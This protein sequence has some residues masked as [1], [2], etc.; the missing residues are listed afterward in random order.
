MLLALNA[1]GHAGEVHNYM[2]TVTALH[3]DGSFMLKKTDGKTMHVEVS[4]STAY[5]HA[6]GKAAT[7]AELAAGK[8]VVV[9][10]STDGKTATTIKLAVAKK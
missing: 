10:I 6:N 5:L 7:R 2:G 4:A 8:R 3:D 1:F 9:T